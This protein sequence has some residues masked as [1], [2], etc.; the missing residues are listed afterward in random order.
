MKKL[1]LIL[2]L[3]ICTDSFAQLKVKEDSFNYIPNAVMDDKDEHVDG[4]AHPMALIMISTENINEHERKRLVFSGNR[5][6]EIN[7]VYKTG[8]VWIYIS[9]QDATFIKIAH[10]DYGTYEYKLPTKLCDFCTYEM[11]L[12]YV[13]ISQNSDVNSQQNNYL[14]ITSDQQ[15]A[16]IYIDDQYVAEGYKLLTV[17]TTHTWKIECDLYHAETGTVTI[18][19]D[20]P[21]V[22]NRKLR[23]AFGYI[24]VNSTPENGAI[25]FI[26]DK[27]VGVTPYQSDKMSCGVY[28]IKVVKD[29]YKTE[30]QTF[31]IADGDTINAV[32]NMTPSFVMLTVNADNGSDIYIDKQ[33]KGNGNW[34]G[35]VADGPHIVEA[36]KD[37]YKPI[38]KNI[39]LVA[40]EDYIVEM[41][42]PAPLTGLLDISTNP[43]NADIYLNGKHYGTT[44]RIIPNL[45]IGNYTLKI[46]KDGYRAVTRNILIEEEHT[47][48]IKEQLN[49][50]ID[51]N[52]SFLTLNAA[53]SIAPQTSFGFT[54]GQLKELGWF[55]SL[56][57]NF[58]FIG[59]NVIDKSYDEVALTGESRTTRISLTGGVMTKLA[60]TPLY[61]RAGAGYGLRIRACETIRGNYAEFTPDTY[62]GLDITAGL[63]FNVSKITLGIDAVITNFKYMELKLGIGINWN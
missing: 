25:V 3:I 50:R 7:K 41:G 18:T 46:E 35:R 39:V 43:I 12:Q 8:Q 42:L 38:V 54:Y 37:N 44:P 5:A 62:E 10:P 58:D 24:N 26:N 47:Y 1:F 56:M 6:T 53:Y 60:E 22:I 48:T 45:M 16:L 2:L 19:S 9:A 21:I 49:P 40:G 11:I 15:N 20:E 33:F 36:M 59:F 32:L 55:V 17:G 23:P 57:S 29:L 14:T 4:N 30:E 51:G 13:P 28:N 27:K 61:L 52:V 34:K 63:M 31:T